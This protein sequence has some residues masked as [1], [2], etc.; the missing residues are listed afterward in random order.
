MFLQAGVDRAGKNSQVQG[1]S[2]VNQMRELIR[3]VGDN[4]WVQT[5]CG[6]V[7]ISAPGA[8]KMTKKQK[9]GKKN[10]GKKK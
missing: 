3:V 4:E 1:E 6:D 9:S 10:A 2:T 5:V 8:S 7:K